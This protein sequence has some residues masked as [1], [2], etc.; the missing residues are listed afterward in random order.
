[1][2]QTILVNLH[3]SQDIRKVE[4]A[5]LNMPCLLIWG[6]GMV[7]PLLHAKQKIN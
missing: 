4:S 7:E 2:S 1:M 5:M 6:K 3:V